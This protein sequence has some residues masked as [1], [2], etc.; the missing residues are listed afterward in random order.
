MQCQGR[1][2]AEEQMLKSLACSRA[3]QLRCKW[4]EGGRRGLQGSCGAVADESDAGAR[5][6]CLA[7]EAR[8]V[9]VCST[10]HGT[11]DVGV[12]ESTCQ[13]PEKPVLV[14]HPTATSCCLACVLFPQVLVAQMLS[15]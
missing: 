13:Q 14:M 10:Q 4:K 3:M 6:F 11:L 1:P 7:Q 15:L 9:A 5:H 8:R 12:A 2:A